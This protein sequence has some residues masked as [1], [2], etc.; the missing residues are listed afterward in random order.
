MDKPNIRIIFILDAGEV[1]ISRT[2]SAYFF[3][4]AARQVRVLLR[5]QQLSVGWMTWIRFTAEDG[6]HLRQHSQ[7]KH[8]LV[9]FFLTSRKLTCNNMECEA[10]LNFL[11]SAEFKKSLRNCFS[12]H[13]KT[14]HS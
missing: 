4:N 1:I 12:V 5:L 11:S 9:I 13:L 2:I 6:F 8:R 14:L 10:D 7:T 3:C